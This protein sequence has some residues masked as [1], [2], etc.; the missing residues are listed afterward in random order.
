VKPV[1]R[2]ATALVAIVC[3]LRSSPAVAQEHPITW[4]VARAGTQ[5]GDT[6]ALR[7]DATVPDG[8]HLYSITQPRGG[9]IAT[10]FAVDP[11]ERFRLNSEIEGPTPRLMPDPNF[12]I[13]SEWYEDSAA[14]QLRVS[15]RPGA[16]TTLRTRVR[17]QACTLR[18]CLPPMEDT[19]T[20]G[21]ANSGVRSPPRPLASVAQGS[22]G[23][24]AL[25]LWVAASTGLLALLTP[26][27][28]PMIPLTIAYFGRTSTS[29]AR[30]VREVALFGA[31]IVGTFTAVG[32]GFSFAF[33]VAGV[34]RIGANAWLNLAIGLFFALF[35]LSLAGKVSFTPPAA[36]VNALDRAARGPDIWRAA[37]VLLMGAVFALTTFTCT[38]P[39]VGSLLVSSATGDWRWPTAGLLVFSTA[40]ALPF[41]MLGLAP[42]AVQRLP[43]SGEWLATMKGTLVFAELAAAVKF[44]AN[45]DM[46]EGWG[47]VTRDVVL[48]AWLVLATLAAAYLLGARMRA[49]GAHSAATR[50]PIAAVGALALGIWLATGLAGR[51]MGELESFLPPRH[52]SS[53][54]ADWIMNDLA[55]ARRRAALEHKLVL[56]DFTG[57]TC[58]NCRW[59]EANMFPRPAVR[60][61]LSRFVRVRLFTDGSGEAYRAQQ[62]YEREQFGTV[63]L[64]L[65]AVIDADER[66]RALFLG[67]TRNADE[68]IRFLDSPH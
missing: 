58:T 3:C 51:S 9:P 65:Y 40:F 19:L 27:A 63:A 25:F 17:Y 23:S 68:F 60:G 21:A 53:T 18:Y 67:M 32:L 50:R 7:V 62:A 8:W 54:D 31:G 22:T 15:A 11:A 14:F 49:R 12:G 37:S 61:A 24:L 38:A 10:T 66:P 39:F 56:I 20:I 57:Y 4:R 16:G 29:R 45:A 30:I 44:I 43:R 64:P 26:C 52:Q 34:N 6:I 5:A 59:M 55:E 47:V 2:C 46:V 33:G 13:M 35:A 48:G 36:L 41:V 42:R 28:F 1:S